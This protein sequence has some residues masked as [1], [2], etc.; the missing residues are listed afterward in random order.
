MEQLGRVLI[1]HVLSIEALAF[2]R[3]VVS[4]TALD[5]IIN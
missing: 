2:M 5:Y 3:D 1:Y 4:G